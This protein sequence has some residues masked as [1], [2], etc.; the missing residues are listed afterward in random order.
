MYSTSTA[1]LDYSALRFVPESCTSKFL[2][3]IRI[4]A[5]HSSFTPL[6]WTQVVTDWRIIKAERCRLGIIRVFAQ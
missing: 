4:S 5:V 1:S 2:I 6:R 3:N